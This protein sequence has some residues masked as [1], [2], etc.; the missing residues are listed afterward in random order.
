MR[1]PKTALEDN[2]A[3]AIGHTSAGLPMEP[4]VPVLE[5]TETPWGGQVVDVALARCS[6]YSSLCCCTCYAQDGSDNCYDPL[7]GVTNAVLTVSSS[8]ACMVFASSCDISNAVSS[9]KVCLVIDAVETFGRW[10]CCCS[11]V[12]S[13]NGI[14][15]C[16][17]C[18]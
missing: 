4:F 11:A 6:E 3:A 9:S 5:R 18:S 12:W 8:G 1:R 10:S 13:T 7:G 14:R 2:K 17:T 15:S 16:E